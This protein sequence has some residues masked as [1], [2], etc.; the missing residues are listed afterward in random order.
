MGER[1]DKRLFILFFFFYVIILIKLIIFKYPAED[2]LEIARNWESGMVLE[3][4]E[5]ANFTLGK[6]VK[7]YIRYFSQLNG[8]ANLFGNVLIFI[9]FGFL[10]P[11]CDVRNRSWWRMA[12]AGFLLSL[13]IELFQLFS[14]FGAFDVDDVLLNVSGAFAGWLIYCLCSKIWHP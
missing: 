6:T 10:F 7:M 1:R 13:G 2:L 4:L 3:G 11:L 9:P 12:G 8:F 14:A 5:T